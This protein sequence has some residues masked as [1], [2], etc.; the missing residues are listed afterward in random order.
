MLLMTMAMSKR[1]TGHTQLLTLGDYTQISRH[2][3]ESYVGDVMQQTRDACNDPTSY[4]SKAICDSVDEGGTNKTLKSDF[5]EA[6]SMLKDLAGELDIKCSYEPKIELLDTE[7]IGYPSVIDAG[8]NAGKEKTGLLQIT[9]RCEFRGREYILQVQYP[10]NVVYRMTPIIKDFMLFADN[11]YEEQRFDVGI[12]DN[13]NLLY[14][15]NGEVVPDE[16]PKYA[17]INGKIRPLVLLQAPDMQVDAKNS[18][19]V[20]LG[21]SDK[22][23][24]LNLAGESP[25]DTDNSNSQTDSS[26]MFLVSPEDLGVSAG[27]RLDKKPVFRK[28]DGTDVQLLGQE[29]ELNAG[30][31]SMG[32]MGFSSDLSD[33]FNGTAWKLSDFLNKGDKTKGTFWGSV[34]EKGESNLADYTS[35]ASGIKLFGI[36]S[37]D[38]DGDPIIVPREIYGNVFSR[39]FVFT[40]WYPGSWGGNPLVYDPDLSVDEVP[41]LLDYSK[42]E[43][44]FSPVDPNDTYQVYMSR[45]MSGLPWETNKDKENFFMPFNINLELHKHEVYDESNFAPADGFSLDGSFK[46]HNFGS[47]WFDIAKKESDPPAPIEKRIG[48]AFKN[49]ED[50]KAA[51]GH[52]NKFKINGV[53][54]VKGNLE[55]DDMDLSADDCSGGIVLVDGQIS[56]G[57]I[58]RGKKIDSSKFKLSDHSAV[59]TYKKWND[60]SSDEYIG[61]DKM[62]TFVSLNSNC[63]LIKGNV[64]LGVQLVS[65]NGKG[66][67]TDQISWD[68]DTKKEI[69]Y[70]GSIVCNRLNL[71]KRLEE[72]GEI[73]SSDPRLAAPFFMYPPVM[74]T[75]TPSLAVQ[76]MENMRGYK[77]NSGK[78]SKNAD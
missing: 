16:Y 59:D 28:R 6:S 38:A 15:K 29:I 76:I 62:L 70:Y 34:L 10:F 71:A 17:G 77:L 37:F 22:S 60:P 48:R 24:Y 5:Y 53:V 65:L 41:T 25:N 8:P 12:N 43:K 50:F 49:Q 72:F 63:I 54:Y 64:L 67:A 7:P 44:V 4:F 42:S 14:I 78:I 21:P 55:L 2:F 58:T 20:Y 23:I 27:G 13:L 19:K 30:H 3:L 66:Y 18:G 32:V 73:N 26:E 1:M 69:I 56:L 46:F 61:Q 11:I 74:A 47:T 31:A 68:L 36:K 51:V 75:G 57:N 33:V 40:F 45:V 35:F 9:C 52:P 39:F